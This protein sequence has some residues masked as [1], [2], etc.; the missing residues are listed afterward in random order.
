M[1]S[2]PRLTANAPELDKL[3][4]VEGSIAILVPSTGRFDQMT[5]RVNRL[6]RGAIERAVESEAF[7][8]GAKEGAEALLNLFMDEM[9]L[10]E[11]Y[12]IELAPTSLNV[13][14]Q[15]GIFQ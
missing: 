8:K 15:P 14:N 7:A 3:A 5:R 13:D 2:P 6:T 4:G 11:G 9:D 1:P 12:R 10:E